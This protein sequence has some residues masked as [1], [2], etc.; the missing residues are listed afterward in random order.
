L[1]VD[2]DHERVTLVELA[3]QILRFVGCDGGAV[4]AGGGAD[5]HDAVETVS[6]ACWDAF[7]A[8]SRAAI[9]TGYAVPHTSEPSV[10]DVEETVPT[11]APPLYTS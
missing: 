4:S 10:D 6:C 7:P 3:F 1:S 8:A 11:L 5:G 2:A 9:P